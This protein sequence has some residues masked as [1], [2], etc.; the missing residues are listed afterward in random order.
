MPEDGDSCFSLFKIYD[1]DAT[2]DNCTSS[3]SKIYDEHASSVYTG[4]GPFLPYAVRRAL[5]LP[6]QTYAIRTAR[7]WAKYAVGSG[8]LGLYNSLQPG[9]TW[10]QDRGWVVCGHVDKLPTE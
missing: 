7:N 9:D 4:Q 1:E 6:A 10:L 2:H 5:Q 3:V 8:D